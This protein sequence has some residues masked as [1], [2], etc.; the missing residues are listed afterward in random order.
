MN[1]W[2][3]SVCMTGTFHKNYPQSMVLPQGRTSPTRGNQ[4]GDNKKNK[5]GE[6]PIPVS[7]LLFTGSALP[8]TEAH[9]FAS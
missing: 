8:V 6:T 1:V 3:S 7:P 4:E 9:T 5:S 2:S